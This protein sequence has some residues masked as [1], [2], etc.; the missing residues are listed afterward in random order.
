MP[1]GPLHS[2]NFRLLLACDVI[3]VTGTAIAA[4]ALP[5]AVFSVGGSASGVGYIATA[6]LIPTIL[7]LLLG[8]VVADR[9]PRHQ[10]MMAANALQALA[11]A[12]SALLVLTGGGGARI[13]GLAV[14]AAVRGVGFGFFFPAAE[15]LLPQ[16]VTADQL[17]RANAMD[18]IGRNGAQIGGAALG[19]ALV[20]WAG[21]G[22][23]LAID[24]ASFAVAGALRALMRF[25]HLPR[26]PRASLPHELREGWRDFVSRR[27]LWAIVVQSALVAA[28]YSAA[29]VL[30][31][32]VAQVRLGG[33][34]SWGIVT[35]A[36]AIGAILGGAVLVRLRVR[37]LLVAASLSASVFALFLGTL[38]VPLTV[39]W[40]AAAALLTGGCLEVS[41]VNRALAVQQEIPPAML[42]RLSSYD[43]LGG[44]ALAPVGAVAA[45]PAADAFGVRAVLAAGAILIAVLTAATLLVPEVRGMRR[46][47]DTSALQTGPGPG[48]GAYARR[49]GSGSLCGPSGWIRSTPPE[50]SGSPRTV[51]PLPNRP[52]ASGAEPAMMDQ[53]APAW[54]L[55]LARPSQQSSGGRLRLPPD[56]GMGGP[57]APVLHS[58]HM[59]T[60]GVPR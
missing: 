8:G 48:S 60:G 50:C 26:A 7:L 27:W 14:L 12:G 58:A 46:R 24:A 39:P 28:I 41:A 40:V 29:G 38:A 54:V 19:G 11:Q 31:P 16:T 13:A 49:P 34:R 20:G 51:P 36:F 30:G 52:R 45:G 59:S 43:V 25:P 55:T 4:V 53:A 10:V 44:L 6:S 18:R 35:A 5:F 37:R 23:G 21:P 15:G 32:L 3:S 2:R 22:W 57:E 9:L 42:S 47:S 1:S 56:S 33:A 17:A